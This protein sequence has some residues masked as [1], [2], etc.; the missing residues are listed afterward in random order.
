MSTTSSALSGS[1]R[2][3]SLNT[4]LI[5]LLV[6]AI[7]FAAADFIY[8]TIKSNH[9]RQASALTT[10]IQV[11]SQALTTYA[12]NAAGGNELALHCDLVVAAEEA[13]FATPGVNIGLFCTTPGVAVARAVPPKQ[14]LELLLT[15]TPI[16][17]LEAHRLGLVNRVV[18]ADRL[19]EETLKLA[20]Q[21]A[22]ASARVVAIGKRAFYEQ[23]QMPRP[24]ASYSQ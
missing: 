10:E 5:V 9:D 18:P 11:A 17:A 12:A 6:L 19:H 4:I 22:Q 21:I 24:A 8:L 20:R 2:T 13:R 3:G 15:G 16:S 23:L 14:A 7:A 1:E